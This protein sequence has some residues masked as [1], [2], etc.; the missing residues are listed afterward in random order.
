MIRA[1]SSVT[2]RVG[3]FL[4][5]DESGTATVEFALLFPPF[6]FVFASSIEAGLMMIRNVQLERGLD[7]AVR[8]IRI[9][10][11][12]PPTFEEFRT[13]ICQQATLVPR[14][15]ENLQVELQ[16][17]SSDT[18]QPLDNRP[19]CVDRNAEIDPFDDPDYNQ[20]GNNDFMLVRLC[21]NVD[22]ILPGFAL[23]ALL[24]RIP[25]EGEPGDEDYQPNGYAIVA[26]SAFVNEPSR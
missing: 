24:D 21:A 18:W 6:F 19:R 3:T 22:P 11:P 25:S 17:V 13:T 5:A 23:G 7:I 16:I 2:Q 26:V 10:T 15:M 8:E 14:C 9:G 12:V 20:G 1:L 4:R